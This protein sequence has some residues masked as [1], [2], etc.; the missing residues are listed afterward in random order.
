MRPLFLFLLMI[1][2][3]GVVQTTQS[4][5]IWSLE[6]CIK[7][8]MENNIQVRQQELGIQLAEQNL[9][10]A[11]AAMVPGLNANASHGYNWGRTV[12]R[13]TNQFATERVQFNNFY[14]SSSVYVFNGF[15]LL[16]TIRKDK[17][18]LQ[19]SQF[20]M[21]KMRNDIS[22]TIAMAYLNI[23]FSQEQL[24]S[25]VGQAEVTRQQVERTR[26]LVDAGTLPKGALL[27]L[28]AQHAQDEKNVVSAENLLD[29]NMLTLVHL[30]DLPGTAGFA[31]SKPSIS[32]PD[33]TTLL[34]TPD[35]IFAYAVENQPSVK[36]ADVRVESAAR[37][38]SIARSLMMPSVAVQGSWGT[39]YSGASQTVKDARITGVDTIGLTLEPTPVFVG[40]PSISYTLEK[41]AFRDQIDQNN[42][43][44]LGFY[45]SIPLFNGLQARTSVSKA[46]I[47]MENARYNY[48]L[49][50]NQLYKDIQQSYADALAAL[51]RYRAADKSRQALQESFAY[52]EQRF[53]VGMAN[54]VEYN[55]AKN[56][57]AQ[58]ESEVLQSKYEYLFRKTIL[59][60]YLGN[61]ITLQ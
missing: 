60:F 21:E 33:N 39:G 44:S 53:E 1:G 42:N 32:L 37:D 41:I 31:I 38:L 50:R 23:L 3:L 17:L 29:Y 4:Q 13:F 27:S 43:T 59:D 8:A 14:L 40:A 57:L 22:L 10:E 9:L 46:K 61:P 30:L 35:Y 24:N 11:K 26:K 2:G 18:E 15:R 5:K 20:D 48:Q 19:A 52:T 58:A 51:K 25:L 45:M 12:D 34:A 28:E 36:S 16:N 56:K 6:D 7:Y 47:G 54:S 49:A 55:D